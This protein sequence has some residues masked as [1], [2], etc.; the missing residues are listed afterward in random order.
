MTNCLMIFTRNPELGV[1]KRRLAAQV[2][3]EKA[4][5]I[6]KFL[7]EHTRSITKYIYGIKQVWYSE[8]V[9]QDDEWD[10]L[11]YEKYE[12]KG[13]D[14]GKRM[15][16]AFEQALQKHESVIVIGS[17]MYDLTALEIDEAFKKLNDHD[18]VI[19]PA[20]DG[21]YY[22]LGFKNKIPEGVF[23]NKEWG[24]ATVLEQTLKDLE[25]TDYVKLEE[26]N[27]VDTLEDIKDHPD[28]QILLN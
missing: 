18:A 28:F 12:Q 1:G 11:T 15:K 27:D 16:Y 9:H 21:G 4:L 3:D 24:T 2:G 20:E 17:D 25:N 10:N 6:Y 22:L 13:A 23:E 14:L 7:L 8:R 5:E 26:R 19:G